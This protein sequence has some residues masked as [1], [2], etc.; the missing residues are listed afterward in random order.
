MSWPLVVVIDPSCFCVED[1]FGP[2]CATCYDVFVG[3]LH[4]LSVWFSHVALCEDDCSGRGTTRYGSHVTKRLAHNS[5]SRKVRSLYNTE[6]HNV[7]CTLAC[8]LCESP[9]LAPAGWRTGVLAPACALSH[10]T[11]SFNEHA[12]SLSQAAATE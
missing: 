4:S 12:S 8:V 1:V 11:V 9:V 10:Y 6:A 5:C 2:W 7:R 3:V